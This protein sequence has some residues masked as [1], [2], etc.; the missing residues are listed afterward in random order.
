MP[1]A[2]IATGCV[3]MILPLEEIGPAI[4]EAAAAL[5][6]DDAA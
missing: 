1:E 5:L 4:V 2:A 3:R 6:S